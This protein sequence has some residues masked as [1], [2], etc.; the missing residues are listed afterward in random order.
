M[1][2]EL[3]TTQLEPT[4][5][6]A[7]LNL[8]GTATPDEIVHRAAAVARSL[9]AVI[10][11]QQLY[12]T[13]QGRRYIRIEGWTL[14][15]S[16]VGVFPVTIWSRALPDGNGWE[17]RVEARTLSGSLVGAAE[18]QCCRDEPNWRDRPEFTL[19][20]MA[21]TRAA[22]KALRLPLGFIA[23]LAGYEATPAEEIDPT[24]VE[25]NVE[26]QQ[27]RLPA[28]TVEERL[29][30]KQQK[31]I[32]MLA[33]QRQFSVQELHDFM[34][35]HDLPVEVHTLS[36]AQASRLISLLERTGQDDVDD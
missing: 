1:S 25:Q 7:P 18:A 35:A 12:V 21:Q 3:T 30:P 10:D 17:A 5:S 23:T 9:S 24:E 34:R 11:R 36:R 2:I 31:L 15:G 32:W 26:Q 22:A 16:L 28:T 20:S 14:L 6:Q 19:R 4:Q 13:I 29:T 27:Q 8:W 33:H